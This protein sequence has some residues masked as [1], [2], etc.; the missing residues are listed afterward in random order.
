MPV[1]YRTLDV[2]SISEQGVCSEDSD[3]PVADR[4]LDGGSQGCSTE[5]WVVDA[6]WLFECQHRAGTG[7]TDW[8][9][10]LWVLWHCATAGA[11]AESEQLVGVG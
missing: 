7:S 3:L 8:G 4:K 2:T 9:L 5:H 10:V 11:D 1:C 6:K